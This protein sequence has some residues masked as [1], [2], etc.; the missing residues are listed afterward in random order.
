MLSAIRRKSVI[1]IAFAVPM[2][3]GAKITRLSAR[4]AASFVQPYQMRRIKI[5]MVAELDLTGLTSQVWI[6]LGTQ[7]VDR[8]AKELVTRQRRVNKADRLAPG[9]LA[10][11]S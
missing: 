8:S 9:I 2:N 6:A 7:G 5:T 3:A 1:A 10:A 11:P 4:S